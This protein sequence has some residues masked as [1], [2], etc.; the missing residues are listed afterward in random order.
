MNVLEGIRL[1]RSFFTR[2]AVEVAPDLLGKLLVRRFEDG[3]ILRYRITETECYRGEE[4]SACHAHK[5]KT[6]RTAIMY[7]IGGYSYIYL[8]YGL[9]HLFNIVTGGENQPQAVLIRGV[10]GFPGPARATKAMSITTALTGID[11]TV[12]DTIWIE[13]DGCRCGYTTDKR[14]GIDYA[15]EPY[16]SI[17]WR[18]VY[19]KSI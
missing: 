3:R 17:E 1:Q 11:M 19:V 5:G 9:H 10:E 4:D 13:D 7:G 15:S 16:K 8:C 12:S 18:F 2:D 6:P 14:V